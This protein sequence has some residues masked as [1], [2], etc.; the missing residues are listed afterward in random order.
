LVDNED[1]ASIDEKIES[2]LFKTCVMSLSW[3]STLTNNFK[4]LISIWTTKLPNMSPKML[5]KW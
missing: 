5:T 4:T 2:E 3:L 1:Y